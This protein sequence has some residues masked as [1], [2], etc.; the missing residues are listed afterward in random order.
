VAVSGAPAVFLD[1]DGTLVR[2]V[3]YN[4][5]PA[6]IELT[7]G[8]G[9]ALRALA[10]AG[11]RLIAISNQ[12]GV[13]RGLFTEDALEGVV[14]RMGEL[15]RA[16]GVA[17]DD[18]LYCPHHPQGS[19]AAYAVS[20]SCRKP[21]PGLIHAAAARHKLDLARSWVVGDILDDVEAGRRAGCRTVLVDNGNETEWVGG[22]L[23]RPHQVARDLPLAARAII[24]ASLL[25]GIGAP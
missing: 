5:D 22:V 12:S 4:V 2:D 9:P 15:L 21:S 24:T 19:V 20:C 1:K 16:H 13:A 6:R 3:P 11:F 25:S 10:G 8:A 7:P 14:R 18:F 23:R 17:L